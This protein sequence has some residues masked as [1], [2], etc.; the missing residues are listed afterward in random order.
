ME[1]QSGHAFAGLYALSVLPG[2][3]MCQMASPLVYDLRIITHT[4]TAPA[5]PAHALP[6]CHATLG[7]T[8]E[9]YRLSRAYKSDKGTIDGGIQVTDNIKIE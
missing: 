9:I 5:A 8:T 6:V 7:S 4:S 3:E 2:M 1:T